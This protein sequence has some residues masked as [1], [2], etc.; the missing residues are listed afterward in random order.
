MILFRR[1]LPTVAALLVWVLAQASFRA[2]VSYLPL[3]AAAVVSVGLATIALHPRP[4]REALLFAAA[5]LL[6]QTGVSLFLLFPERALVRQL[7]AAAAAAG[8]WIY[9]EQIFAYRYRTASFQAF[10]LE[11]IASYLD[12]ASVFLLTAGLIGL[13]YA[14]GFPLVAAFVLL[15][16]VQ[17]VAGLHAL[18]MAKVNWRPRFAAAL[19]VALFGTE[20]LVAL[21]TLPADAAVIALLLA[22]F[23][24]VALTLTHYAIRQSLDREHL[25]RYVLLAAGVVLFTVLTTPWR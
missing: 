7:I 23:H 21:T 25:R 15:A 13:R 5:P 12:L 18:A 4:R 19:T 8:L 10:A 2:P 1:I 24:F 6:F 14:I 3:A 9:L 20:L 16:G 17:F 11:H 22:T